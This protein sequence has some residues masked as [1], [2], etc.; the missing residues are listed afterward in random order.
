MVKT[1]NAVL[2]IICNCLTVVT[3]II[4]A[5]SQLTTSTRQSNINMYNPDSKNIWNTVKHK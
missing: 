2:L 4:F 1:I 3:V 5:I